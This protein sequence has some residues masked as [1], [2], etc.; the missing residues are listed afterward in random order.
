MIT[1]LALASAPLDPDPD[2]AR[3]LLQQELSDPIY[4]AAEPTL[5]DRVAQAI[6]DFLARLFS[7]EIPDSLG[8]AAAIVASVVV[9]VA[10]VV[11]LL[12]WGRPR[13]RA[14]SARQDAAMF[15]AD[16]IRSADELRALARAAAGEE[17]WDDAIVL[18]FRAIARSLAERVVVNPAPGATA[19][20]F[21]REAAEAFPD[22]HGDLAEAARAFDDVR[23]LRRPGTSDLYARMTDLDEQLSRSRPR[24]LA[25]LA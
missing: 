3:E 25:V 21:A 7:P 5:F 12:V 14:R 23:Y 15:G 18:R 9:A 16:D 24:T 10:V 20:S 4:A 1:F 13:A 11:A 22:A 6:G 19:Q 8:P 2:R 17:R